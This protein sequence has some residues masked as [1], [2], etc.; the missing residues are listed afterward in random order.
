MDLKE[1]ERVVRDRDRWWAVVN[2]VMNLRV[3]QSAVGF[4]TNLLTVSV[5]IQALW[6]VTPCRL[7]DSYHRSSAKVNNMWMFTAT[8]PYVV[9]V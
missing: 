8:H 3:V 1:Q 6:V 2:T 5:H 7:S 4:L 9:M